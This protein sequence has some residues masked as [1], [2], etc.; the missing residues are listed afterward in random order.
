[1]VSQGTSEALPGHVTV[2]LRDPDT[3]L[4]AIQDL[5]SESDG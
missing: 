5:L 2:H 4:Q 3:V 1:V